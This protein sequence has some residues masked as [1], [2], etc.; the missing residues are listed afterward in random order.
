MKLILAAESGDH[1]AV[2]ST[3]L[4]EGAEAATVTCTLEQF[5]V[6]T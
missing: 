6:M 2:V 3:A 1:V 4:G 5:R